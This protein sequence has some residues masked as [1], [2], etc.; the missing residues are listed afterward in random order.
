M[1]KVRLALLHEGDVCFWFLHEQFP[2]FCECLFR[3]H[4][5]FILYRKGEPTKG[6]VHQCEAKCGHHFFD[7]I[8]PTL[9]GACSDTYKHIQV[10]LSEQG[11]HCQ[12]QM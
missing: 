1:Y 6:D 11:N 3:L 9:I 12:L 10:Q 8:L 7:D 4:E 2:Y 5:I